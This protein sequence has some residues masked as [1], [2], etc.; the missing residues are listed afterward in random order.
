VLLVVLLNVGLDRQT[1]ELNKVFFTASHALFALM[2]GYGMTLMAA[3]AA[4]HYVKFRFWGIIGSSVAI[5]L[6]L[7]CLA[8][9]AAKLYVGPGGE[10]TSVL[11]QLP[12]LVV[13]AFAK[14]QYG[15]PILANLIL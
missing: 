9:A 15:L 12:H 13:R 5:I 4:T 7:Y 6:A 10:A 11:S 14:D 8:D 3:Y 1:A 2:I